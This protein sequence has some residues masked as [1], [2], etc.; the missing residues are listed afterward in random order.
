MRELRYGRS[1]FFVWRLR[2]LA[3]GLR[4][5]PRGATFFRPFPRGLFTLKNLES[6]EIKYRNFNMLRYL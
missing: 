4:R 6:Q 5:M 3:G 2:E 1:S